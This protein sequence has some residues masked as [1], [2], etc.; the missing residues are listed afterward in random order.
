MAYVC[1]WFTDD[2]GVNEILEIRVWTV[3]GLLYY[4]L[5]DALSTF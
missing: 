4:D 2:S 3:F 5:L 1:P